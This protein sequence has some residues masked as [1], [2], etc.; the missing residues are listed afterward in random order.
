[1]Q[2]GRVRLPELASRE[3]LSEC[4]MRFAKRNWTEGHGRRDDRRQHREKA[5]QYVLAIL[6]IVKKVI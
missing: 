1:M 4:E 5:F 6:E 3:G 2:C